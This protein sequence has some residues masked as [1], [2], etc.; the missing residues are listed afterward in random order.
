VTEPIVSAADDGSPDAA[1]AVVAVAALGSCN[2]GPEGDCCPIFL[3]GHL[4]A[5]LEQYLAPA[6]VAEVWEAYHTAAE[7]HKTQRRVSGEPYIYHPLAAAGILAE[8]RLDHR[9]VMAALLH[10]V[11]E[12]TSITKQDL[13]ERFGDTVAELVDGVSKLAHIHFDSREEAQAAN[14]R[15][16]VLAMAQDIRVILVKLAD[17]LHNMRTLGAMPTH[18]RNRIAHETLDIYA[19]IANR[20]GINAMRL[21]LEDLGFRNLYPWRSAILGRCVKRARGER[22]EVFE[23]IDTG[24]R[25]RLRQEGLDGRVL[26]RTK[27]LS[28]IYRKMC[29]KQLAFSEVQDLQAFRII[30]DTVDTC[31]RVLGTM[32]NL[33]KPVPGKFK[34]YIAIPKANGYQS[35]HTTL[36][37]PYGVHV[38]VQVRTEEM[39]RVAEAGVAAHWLYKSDGQHDSNADSRAR[40]WLQGLLEMQGNSGDSVEFIE[41]VKVDLFPDEVYVF[42]PKGRIMELP[43][44]ATPVDFAYAVHTDVGNSCVAAK[45][46]RRLTPLHRHLYNGQ[47]VEIITAEGAMPKPGWLNFVVTAKART[48]IRHH[49]KQI[50]SDEAAIL[51]RRLL[52]KALS[53]YQL[54]LGGLPHEVISMLLAETKRPSLTVL[55]EDIGGGN[56]LPILVARRLA[57]LVDSAID[58]SGLGELPEPRPLLIRGTEGMVVNFAKCCHPIPGDPIVGFLSAGKG[59]VVHVA[60]CHNVSKLDDRPDKWIEVDWAEDIKRSFATDVRVDVDNRRG[61][62]ATIA[63]SIASEDADI[64]NVTIEERDGMTSSL[65]F[66]IEVRGRVHLARVMKRLRKNSAV[67]RI[68]RKR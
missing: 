11:V 48:N 35:L 67:T 9:S 63:S 49:L 3:I 20:L 66:T 7:A 39:D 6:Q 23:K 22:R 32:H 53:G 55:L 26:G 38:E 46:D 28:S 29:A 31:Y 2:S 19:P 54:K 8:M 4:C 30:V 50:H 1:P 47:Q 56:R 65:D 12:D 33:Y 5:I 24:I 36:I 57:Q 27:H 64:Q 68:A 25:H 41:N 61:V 34:D 40:E 45:V 44:G 51:G 18:K 10:D 17:R 60:S 42:S 16:M 43:R 58:G 14:L 13:S 21:E 37:G 15:K 52:D 62:L 59:V